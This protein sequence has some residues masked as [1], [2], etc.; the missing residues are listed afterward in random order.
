MGEWPCDLL[1]L[2]AGEGDRDI[3]QYDPA[4]HQISARISG[5]SGPQ[6]WHVLR[7]SFSLT[8]KIFESEKLVRKLVIAGFKVGHDSRD[9][10][11]CK[12]LPYLSPKGLPALGIVWIPLKFFLSNFYSCRVGYSGVSPINLWLKNCPLTSVITFF[13]FFVQLK[14][15]GALVALWL[16]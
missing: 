7:V 13:L 10:G 9:T 14:S 8:N 11:G 12:L 6:L 3:G 16:L 5:L 2:C 15:A 4:P 1:W